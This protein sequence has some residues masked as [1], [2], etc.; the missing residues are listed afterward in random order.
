MKQTSQTIKQAKQGPYSEGAAFDG[1]VAFDFGAFATLLFLCVLRRADG[2]AIVLVRIRVAGVLQLHTQ[3]RVCRNT[4]RVTARPTSLT[5]H[6]TSNT[7]IS[8]R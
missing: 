5:S 1:G 3:T 2:G 7:S 6:R 8:G 4:E